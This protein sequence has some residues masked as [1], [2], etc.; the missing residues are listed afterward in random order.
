MPYSYVAAVTV[1]PPAPATRATIHGS[2]AADI[3]DSRQRNERLGQVERKDSAVQEQSDQEHCG[4]RKK[5]DEPLLT[6][7]QPQMGGARHGPGRQADEHEHA[8][9]GGRSCPLRSR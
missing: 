2:A 4:Q 1:P 8:W 7:S 5:E 6:S 3:R 9:L